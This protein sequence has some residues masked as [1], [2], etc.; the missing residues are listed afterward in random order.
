MNVA[1]YGELLAVG[2]VYVDKGRERLE[3]VAYLKEDLVGE[4]AVQHLL[5]AVVL[6]ELADELVGDLGRW[7]GAVAAADDQLES[8]TFV[9]GLGVLLAQCVD[10]DLVEGRLAESALVDGDGLL[11]RHA[12]DDLE[13]LVVLGLRVL[14][15][16]PHTH[17]VLVVLER[18]LELA[19]R[20]VGRGA[21]V[22]ALYVV[23]VE[24]K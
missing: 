11:E 7:R 8:G 2:H 22:V 18:Q 21:P 6:D 17:H 4:L 24:L 9:V 16:G 20:Q 14:V 12:L 13:A 3:H 5:A 10:V 1:A 15:A 19:Q 23:L